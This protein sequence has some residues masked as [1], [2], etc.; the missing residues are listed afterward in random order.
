M[1]K[2]FFTIL[3]GIS[4]LQANSTA[5]KCVNYQSYDHATGVTT[6]R[7]ADQT[8]LVLKLTVSSNKIF[9]GTYNYVYSKNEISNGVPFKRY[10]NPSNNDA[11]LFSTQSIATSSQGIPVYFAN[12][13]SNKTDLTLLC[14]DYSQVIK[15]GGK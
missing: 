11:M 14:M 9:D 6:T 13:F 8:K 12:F 5:Y 2:I 15:M 1:M 4:Y 10:V 3:L 7:T